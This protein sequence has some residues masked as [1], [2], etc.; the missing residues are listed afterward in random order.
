MSEAGQKEKE[1]AGEM[2]VDTKGAESPFVSIL[3]A[4][5]E[6][7]LEKRRPAFYQDLNID[8][9]ID[10]IC[11]LWGENVSSFYGYFPADE[12]CEDYRRE[13]LG[14]VKLTGVYETLRIFTEKMDARR[15]VF[16][17]KEDVTHRLQKAAW[18]VRE[19]HDY[20][21]AFTE[22]YEALRTVPFRSEG[23]RSF[24]G[25]LE[26]YLGGEGFRAMQ[27]E[28]AG[29]LAEMD[30]FRLVLTYENDRFYVAE[31]EVPG[32]YDAFLESCFPGQGKR[33]ESPFETVPELVDL[34]RE[35]LKVF[36]K[37]SPDFFARAEAF[38]QKYDIYAEKILLRFASEIRYYLS[39]YCFEKNMEELGFRFCVPEKI[40]GQTLRGT[41]DP[42]PSRSG[43]QRGTESGNQGDGEDEPEKRSA[44]TDY[45]VEQ[46]A[47][48]DDSE[49]RGVVIDS[50]VEQGGAVSQ[51][52]KGSVE[53]D[54]PGDRMY[55]RGLY[56]LALACA[57]SGRAEDI[58]SNHMEYRA[59]ESFFVV[60]GPNQGGKTTFARSLGQMVYLAKM[61][62]DI[63]AES[64]A[65][66]HFP[67]LL[68]HFSVE[69]STQTGRGKLMDELVRLVPIMK[70]PCE[71]NF[72][73]INELFTTAA[74]YD[75]CIMGK[76]VLE[77]LLAQGC[78]GIYVTHL[79]ELGEERPGV[80]SL[81][82]MLDGQGERSF[83]IE[84][85][86]AADH[87]S[88]ESQAIKYGL[89]YGQLR[90]RLK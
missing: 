35:L 32:A 79:A 71:G 15:E 45:S 25:Y 61:G 80:A 65:L 46:G 19:I 85:D 39:Y 47:K 53:T 37:K 68:T 67:N 55:A 30:T 83:K 12:A 42:E 27:G 73:V 2:G 51:T 17:K 41:R 88:A 3:D 20:C 5:E 9:I 75:A 78:M 40:A 70:A 10:R 31:G 33:M 63:P 58:V 38:Y 89:T 82:A 69:E 64:A 16:V 59:G 86:R 50:P 56:D 13:V 87:A 74:N 11:R 22:L 21:R 44:E 72:V 26:R 29:L 36:Q 66:Y 6:P 57:N 77:H 23:M 14:D 28:A 49:K 18:H 60:T 34:E 1:V 54:S 81:R 4:M 24:L 7:D 48:V 43:G 84:R 62:L 76:R 52:E 8:Q 90:E